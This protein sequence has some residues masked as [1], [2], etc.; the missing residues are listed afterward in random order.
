MSHRAGDIVHATDLAEV[1]G[2]YQDGFGTYQFGRRERAYMF[3]PPC[4]DNRD[5]ITR[6]PSEA[7]S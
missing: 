6:L 4:T 2:I 1:T 3:K 5:L 7:I